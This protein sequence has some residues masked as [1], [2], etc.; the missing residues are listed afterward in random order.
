MGVG[1]VERIPL[2]GGGLGAVSGSHWGRDD[3]L[4]GVR[5]GSSVWAEFPALW[6]SG[7]CGCNGIWATRQACRRAKQMDLAHVLLGLL[8]MESGNI[9][10]TNWLH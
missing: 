2:V 1:V 10:H 5:R 9:V 3:V 4:R 7:R 8:I 6:D